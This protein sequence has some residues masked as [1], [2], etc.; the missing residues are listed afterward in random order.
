MSV[1]VVNLRIDKGT[2]FEKIFNVKNADESIFVLTGYTASAKLKK[3][4]ASSTSKSFDVEITAS[5]G[6]IKITMSSSVTSELS[7]GLNV[8]D[9]TITETAT[10]EIT[11][12]F[13]GNA[14]VYP[15]VSV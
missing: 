15:S 7:V 12:V 5:S 14:T 11:K 13:E 6:Q 4:S 10:S 2:S 3:N 1:P 8:Y 9:I